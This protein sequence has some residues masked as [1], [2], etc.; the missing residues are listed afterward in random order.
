MVRTQVANASTTHDCVHNA[1]RSNASSPARLFLRT[2]HRVRIVSR[3]AGKRPAIRHF[4][5]ALK[6]LDAALLKTIFSFKMYVCVCEAVTDHDIRKAV[7]DGASSVAEVMR[8]TRAGT[9]CGSCRNELH[10]VVNGSTPGPTGCHRRLEMI[11][12]FAASAKAA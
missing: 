8:C 7:E 2:Q 5:K 9:K 1:R 10:D 12:P 4:R 6:V 11:Q 3:C